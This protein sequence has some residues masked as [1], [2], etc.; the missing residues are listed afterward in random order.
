M[1]Y[2]FTV[3]CVSVAGLLAAEGIL[4]LR[5]VADPPAFAENPQYGFLMRG[6]QTVSTRGYRFHI[7]KF[8][9]RGRD[10]AMP[11]PAGIYRIA[12]LGDS[13][14]YSGGS[15]QDP[16]LFVNV[17]AS[18]VQLPA[19]C[20]VEAINISAPGWGI[21]NIASYVDSV[22]SYDAD[23]V[24]WVVP[25][26]DFRRLQTSLRN[27]P[28]FPLQ[29]PRLRLA[30]VFKAGLR[31]LAMRLNQPE[32]D[33]GETEETLEVLTQNLQTLQRVLGQVKDQGTPVVVV[34]VPPESGYEPPS[35]ADAFR[36]TVAA[37]AVPLLDLA[38]EI[39]GHPK[40]FIDQV[41]LSTAGHR[42]VGEA[43]ADFLNKIGAY[44]LGL[45]NRHS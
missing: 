32:D 26:A 37:C 28:G 20:R 22:G 27:Y 25:A 9:L 14:S 16:D 18:R 36:A 35:D 42:V 21:K 5:D 30:W 11:K 24:V 23:L 12:F 17:V 31:R 8:G 15:V 34:L 3:L 41:H 43:I 38:P 33:Q 44:I 1:E 40:Y 4:R 10:F 7:N 2:V 19:D 45:E 39:Q 6:N 13:I 29:K